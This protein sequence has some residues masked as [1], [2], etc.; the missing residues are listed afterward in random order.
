MEFI[1]E[2][3]TDNINIE[4]K[5]GIVYEIKEK[6]LKNEDIEIYNNLIEFGFSKIN[7]FL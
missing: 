4:Y 1:V 7:L 5:E 2:P 6:Q 3:M